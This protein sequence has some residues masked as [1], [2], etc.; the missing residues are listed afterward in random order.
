MRSGLKRT[1]WK[2]SIFFKM[3][4]KI[5][6]Q[7]VLSRPRD[8]LLSLVISKRFTRIPSPPPT[9]IHNS[10]QFLNVVFPSFSVSLKQLQ[11]NNTLNLTPTS[12][13]LIRVCARTYAHTTTLFSCTLK[14]SFFIRF[15]QGSCSLEAPIWNST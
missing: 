6:S 2:W 4:N 12:V 3:G 9:H 10:F 11:Y 14:M 1:F 8:R 7:G 13:S 5:T 15:S